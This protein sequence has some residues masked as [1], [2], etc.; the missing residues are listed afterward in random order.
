MDGGVAIEWLILADAAQVVGNKL[1]L[2]GGGWDLLTVNQPFP[3]TQPGAVAVSLRV[4]WNETNE[5]HQIG[6]EILTE[7]GQSLAKAGGD[8]EVGRP[9][10]IRPGQ[11]Q[12]LQIAFNVGLRLDAPGTY[13]IV[14]RVEGQEAARI[15]FTAV[16]G[17]GAQQPRAA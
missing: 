3:A 16:A 15:H 8:F 9:P 7:D 13:A 17:P 1:Y 14:G 10:G 12:R 11:D 4:P 6:L 2:L 5:R